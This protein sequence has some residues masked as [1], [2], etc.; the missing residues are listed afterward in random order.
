[1]SPS[2]T[3]NPEVDAD[4]EAVATTTVIAGLRNRLARAGTLNDP[5]VLCELRKLEELLLSQLDQA[6]HAPGRHRSPVSA[7]TS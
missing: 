2:R 4:A 1:M 7:T 6:G 5:T 3:T